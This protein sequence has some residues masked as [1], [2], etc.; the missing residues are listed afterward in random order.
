MGFFSSSKKIYRDDFKKTLRK[1]PQLSPNERHYV[2][3]VF[4]DSLKDGLS[5]YEMKKEISR[6]KRVS[7]DPLDS[8]EIDK[9]KKKLLEHF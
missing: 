7:G 2:E 9:L 8:F 5:E 1:I 4:S 3:G 6:L